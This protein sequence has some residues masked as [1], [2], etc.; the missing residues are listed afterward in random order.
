VISEGMVVEFVFLTHRRTEDTE[1]GRKE[2]AQNS[3]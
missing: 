3:G 2:E 1:R